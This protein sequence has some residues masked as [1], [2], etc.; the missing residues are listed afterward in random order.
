LKA[1]FSS[2][3]DFVVLFGPSGAGKTLTLQAIAGLTEPDSGRIVVGDRL[4]F[5]S[6]TGVNIPARHR[7]VGYVFQDYALF[8]HVTV[9]EN[10]AFGIKRVWQWHLPEEDRLRVKDFLEIF[11]ISHLAPSL[12]RDISGGQRQRV[13][14]ARSLIGRPELLLLDEPFAALDPLLRGRVR[15]EFLEIR[16]RFAIPV[17]MITHDPE[18]IK[19]FAETLV[20][21]EEGRVCRVEPHLGKN[22][23]ESFDQ[24]L[25]SQL[26]RLFMQ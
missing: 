21:Y 8:P 10:V 17:I 16:E 1:S 2:E 4:L 3:E 14:L 18:D 13:A 26:G 12:P 22:W 9:F 11:E 15:K 5:D 7:R 6:G 20:I 24:F 19:V 23:E 25:L